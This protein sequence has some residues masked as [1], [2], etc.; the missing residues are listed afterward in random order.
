[1]KSERHKMY[2]VPAITLLGSA[3]SLP[4]LARED[5][6]AGTEVTRPAAEFDVDG[7]GR[8]NR[9]D[10]HEDI[11]DRLEPAN[12][13]ERSRVNTNRN[14]GNTNRGRSARVARSR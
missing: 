5:D 10:R 2:Q 3:L 13:A 8:L 6:A 4:A 12:R 11:R 9:A 1:M 14:D 7:D